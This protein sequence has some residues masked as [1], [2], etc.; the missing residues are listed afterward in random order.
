MCYTTSL[1]KEIKQ[2]ETHFN[3]KLKQGLLFE[4]TSINL[5]FS[6]NFT[7]IIANDANEM[8]MM[9]QWGLI[10]HWA[11]N[12]SF[13]K[14][15]L[16]AKIETIS[17]VTSFKNYLN[18]RCLILADGFYEWQW[19]D[20]KGKTKQKFFISLPGKELFAFAGLYSDYTRIETGETYRTY[21]MVTT[22]ANK[23]MAEIHNT[24]KRMPVILLPEYENHWLTLGAMEDFKKIEIQLIA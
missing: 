20:S 17:E 9:A 3:R 16:N 21:T 14:N 23:L 7:P 1:D 10:P 24:K 19:Q 11:K 18:N 6:H 13:Q 22:D 2:I 5:G 15:T 8:I 4:P 12:T